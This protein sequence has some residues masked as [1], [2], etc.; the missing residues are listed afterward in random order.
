ME[1]KNKIN[2]WTEREDNFLISEIFVEKPYDKPSGSVERGIIWEN[3]ARSLNATVDKADFNVTGRSVRDRFKH[4]RD[5]AIRKRNVE[6]KASG[7]PGE[8]NELDDALDE[9]DVL[10][11]EADLVRDLIV[12]QKKNK[13]EAERKKAVEMRKQ[14]L[15]TYSETRKRTSDECVSPP[16]STKRMK[17]TEPILEYLKVKNEGEKELRER[18]L[19]LREKEMAVREKEQK[20]SESQMQQMMQMMLAQQN[21]QNQMF[22]QL[23]N[24]FTHP[25]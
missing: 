21:Q 17:K 7:I 4:L 6:E 13:V 1:K 12:E 11:K 23:F 22:M 15:E 20:Q 3:I 19:S 25:N 8:H 16:T 18:E 24:N 14:S 10:F 2:K 5:K 9:L